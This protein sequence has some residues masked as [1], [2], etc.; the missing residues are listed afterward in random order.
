MVNYILP[1]RSRSTCTIVNIPITLKYFRVSLKRVAP[2]RDPR[3]RSV[4]VAMRCHTAGPA[5]DRVYGPIRLRLAQA[6]VCMVLPLQS[7]QSVQYGR[8]LVSS[9]PQYDCLIYVLYSSNLLVFQSTVLSFLVLSRLSTYLVH[10]TVH[11]DGIYEYI[12]RR[13]L[14][15]HRTLTL[16]AP[17]VAQSVTAWH[18][19]GCSSA[20][21]CRDYRV[22]LPA[23]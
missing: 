22:G 9:C 19:S 17:S 12:M 1:G 2:F 21:V 14:Y 15:R 20:A 8:C 5:T 7:R 13:L 18:V 6:Y 16:A 3:P 23:A 11:D 4:L 10:C